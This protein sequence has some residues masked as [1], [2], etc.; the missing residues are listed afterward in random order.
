MALNFKDEEIEKNFLKLSFT[1]AECKFCGDTF[2]HTLIE[3]FYK[4]ICKLITTIL[5][6]WKNGKNQNHR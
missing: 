5:L 3:D 2:I 6:K 4:H 1:K